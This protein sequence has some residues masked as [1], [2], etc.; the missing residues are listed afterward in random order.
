MSTGKM[1]SSLEPF[2]SGVRLADVAARAGV[3]VAVASVALRGVSGGTVRVSKL[4]VER[5]RKVAREMSYRPN[6]AAQILK[7]RKNDVIGVL[8][9]ADSTPANY[10]RLSAIEREAYGRGYRLM[11]GQFHEDPE[12]TAGSIDDFLCRGIDSLI[13]FHNPLIPADAGVL[14]LLGQA[15]ALV[16]QTEVLVKGACLVDVD[17]AAGVVMGVGQL[18]GRGCRRIGLLLNAPHTADSLMRDRRNG[19]LAALKTARG[20]MQKPLIWSGTGEYPP[21][22]ALVDEA[23]KKLVGEGQC[24]GVFASNDV[25]AIEFIK[26]LRRAGLRVPQDVAVVG[27][28]NLQAGA[29]F[30]PALTTIDQNNGAFARAAVDLILETLERGP[31]PAARRERVVQPALI[32][33]ESA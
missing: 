25:W 28:D 17:R 26:G 30:D 11:I 29:L 21:S 19:Y 14:K 31:L 15:R 24:D 23:V 20:K 9:G 3:S 1:I 27:F 6:M 13:C 10:G 4:T 2:K 22:R 32:V 5:V 33:R 16:F 8:I 12:H 7:G 18:R